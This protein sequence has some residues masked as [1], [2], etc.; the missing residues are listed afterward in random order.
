MWTRCICLK[1]DQLRVLANT[2]MNLWVPLKGGEFQDWM[3]EG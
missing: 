3:S 2:V 1:T